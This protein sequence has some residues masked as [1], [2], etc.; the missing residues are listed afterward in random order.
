[1]AVQQPLEPEVGHDGGDDAAALE[2]ATSGPV[3]GDQGHDL[4]AVDDL[5]LL[6]TD[7]DPVGVAI[8]GDPDVGAIAFDRL[9]Q[10][11]GMGRAAVGVDIQAVGLDAHGADLGP[12]LIEGGRG[13]PV[14]RAVGA[15]D[16]HAQPLEAEPLGEAGLGDLDIAGLGIVDALDPAQRVGR[17]QIGVERLIHHRFDL[18]LDGVRKF[19]A[20][21]A[22]QFDAV[23][24]EGVVR[25]RDHHPDVGAHRPGH[26]GHA[27]GRQGTEGA[28]VHTRRGKAR[29]QRRLDHVA[30]QAGVLADD[31]QMAA[32]VSGH[33][34]ATGRKTDPQGHFRRH[35]MGIGPATNAVGTEIAS[36]AQASSSLRGAAQKS[37]ETAF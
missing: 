11:L 19:V 37:C 5:A 7:D 34:Q 23:V 9:G 18:Q 16:C 14:S 6:V 29:N 36:L 8:Q 3:Q 30:G 2:H 24:E 13:D 35:R 33:E 28:H 15:V 31:R 22:E 12:Q 21:G 17:C 26:H 27:R 10:G 4:V 20:V 32:V 1:M 25:G